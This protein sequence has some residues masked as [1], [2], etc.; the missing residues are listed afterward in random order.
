M[1]ICLAFQAGFFS[2][3]IFSLTGC[4]LP[5]NESKPDAPIYMHTQHWLNEPGVEQHLS[6]GLTAYLALDEAF[7]SIASRVHLIRKAQHTIDLQYYIWKDDYIGHMMLQELLKAADRGVKVRLLIDD[8]NGTQ[9]DKVLKPLALHPNF[10]IKIFNP[11]K[12]RKL[13]IVDYAFRFKYI[14]HRMHNKLIIAD[15]AI[16]VTGGRNIS[17]EYFDASDNFQFT[18]LDILFY[19]TA[20][21]H[22]NEVFSD[23]W[24]DDLS[25]SA[26]QL[27]G[28][29]SEAELKKLRHQYE[30]DATQKNQVENKIEFAQKQLDKDLKQRSF[31]WA[32]AHFVADSPDKI[33]GKASGNQLIYNQMHHLMGEPKKHM[34]L[35]SAY[36]VPTQRG[37][38]YLS[39]LSKNNIQVRVLTNSFAANDVAVVHAFYNK[40]RHELLKNGVK[41]YEFKPYLERKKRTWYEVMTGNVIPAKGKSASSLHAK[42]FDI[43]GIVFIG[44][45]NFDPRSVNLNTEVGLVVESDALQNDISKILNQYLPQIAYQLKLNANN[46]IIWTDQRPDGSIHEF[47]ID[48]G[49]TRFQRFSMK[50]VSYLPIE[51]MM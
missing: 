19:G 43:D 48:P 27:L 23:F 2:L 14:N 31:N 39:K 5:M 50:A 18:D 16:A 35:V 3:I 13:R 32:P 47:K 9:L 26:S 10:E 40:Y 34:E 11:Y 38:D 8:Q 1:Q 44:S 45:F 49:T 29:S 15:G 36:F 37:A 51:W 17:R 21:K 22:A 24:N 28:T 33:R 46:E 12:F 41:L 7:M 42:F 6:Q 30:L 4:S 25:Y 20:V